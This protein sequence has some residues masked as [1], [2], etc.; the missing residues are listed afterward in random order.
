[1]FWS[2]ATL[3]FKRSANVMKSQ[4]PVKGEDVICNSKLYMSK[5]QM[6]SAKD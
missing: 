5:Q 1:M 2:R 6:N 4:E 3:F